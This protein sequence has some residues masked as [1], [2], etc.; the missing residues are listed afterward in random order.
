MK[1]II[2]QDSLASN[3]PHIK[4]AMNN[5]FRFI[6]RAKTGKHTLLFDLFDV[7]L[8]RGRHGS[9]RTGRPATL[10]G[11]NGIMGSRSTTHT[12]PLT[13]VGIFGAKGIG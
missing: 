11:S 4:T 6:L 9:D 12:P 5:D 13:Q 2:V 3:G 10:S 1:A 8:A 7:S